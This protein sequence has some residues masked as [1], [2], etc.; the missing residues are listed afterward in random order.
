MDCPARELRDSIRL[1]C[2]VARAQMRVPIAC[3]LRRRM[4]ENPL[5]GHSSL[6][7]FTRFLPLAGFLLFSF[8]GGLA[9]ISDE[10]RVD[11]DII[12]GIRNEFAH[13]FDH[14]LAFTDQSI[15]DRCANLKTAQAYIEG[16]DIAAPATRRNL[17]SSAIYAIRDA[18]KPPRWRFQLSVEFL[19]QYLDTVSTGVQSYSGSDLLAEIR[20][21]SVGRRVE[22]RAEGTVESPETETPPTDAG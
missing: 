3:E 14:E 5:L 13:S 1:S 4:A 12:R 10:V 19:Q 20:A 22:L 7:G 17:S 8:G 6:A 2:K 11:L 21:L 16:F 9:L 18:F 15:S